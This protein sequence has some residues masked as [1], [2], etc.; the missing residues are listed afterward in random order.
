MQTCD[1]LSQLKSQVIQTQILQILILLSQILTLCTQNS[2]GCRCWVQMWEQPEDHQPMHCKCEEI[3][4]LYIFLS[5]SFILHFQAYQSKVEGL[6][7]V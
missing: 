3:G 2:E 1:P 4:I 6:G 5:Y 7:G